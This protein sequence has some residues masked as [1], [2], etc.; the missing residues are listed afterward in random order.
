PS[1]HSHTIETMT[2]PDNRLERVR[3]LWIIS[4][5]LALWGAYL[6]VGAT[7][8]FTPT[9]T[10]AFDV[11]KFFI[12][13][14]CSVVFLAFW[15]GNIRLAKRRAE[16]AATTKT[17]VSSVIAFALS[18]VAYGLWAWARQVDETASLRI[19]LV[20]AVLF[21]ASMIAAMVGISDQ[22]PKSQRWAGY[23]AFAMFLAAIALFIL[24]VRA[25]AAR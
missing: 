15:W 13:A 25:F 1:V 14:A 16:S 20:S 8:L 21:G 24:Q 11:R 3:P 17:S 10:A 2:Q 5:V 23:A 9:N 12:V 7:N 4:G 6:A 22:Q 19:G 18:I